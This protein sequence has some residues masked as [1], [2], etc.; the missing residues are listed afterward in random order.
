[1]N[2]AKTPSNR[3]FDHRTRTGRGVSSKHESLIRASNDATLAL[4]KT[5]LRARDAANTMEGSL[6]EGYKIVDADG[7]VIG[8]RDL[9]FVGGAKATWM[10][11]RRAGEA[12]EMIRFS[13]A[14]AVAR[15]SHH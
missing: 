13:T 5:P 14:R 10:P 6:P 15:L 8:C 7:Y 11:A 3:R 2:T 4:L 12:G 9:V 1:M